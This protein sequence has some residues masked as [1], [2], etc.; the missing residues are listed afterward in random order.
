MQT[1]RD[2]IQAYQFSAG[3]L[4]HAVTSGDTGTGEQPLRRGNLGV[5]LGTVIAMLLSGGAVVYGLISP[6]ADNSWK[7]QG[8]IIVE[9]ET[10]TRYVLL[11]G[12]LRPTANYASARL[13]GS[14]KPTIY[15][16]KH[17]ALAAFPIGP[18]IGIAGAPDTLPTAM[19]DGAWSLCLG[20]AGDGADTVL[21]LVPAGHTAAVPQQPVLITEAAS[22]ASTAATAA[23]A[24]TA[25]TASGGLGSAKG[26]ASGGGTAASTSTGAAAGGATKGAAS[27]PAKTTGKTADAAPG[28][29]GIGSEYVLWGAKKYPVPNPSVLAALGLG[30]E[31]PLQAS[32]TW[33]GLLPTGDPLSPAPVAS[34]HANGPRIAGQPARV[35]QLFQ[36]TAAGVEQFYVLLT[37]GLAPITRTEAALFETVHGAGKPASVDPSDIAAAPVSA[38][39]S[40]L[41]RLPDLM[42][43]TPFS[44]GQARLCVD[45]A[46]AGAGGALALVTEDA[47]YFPDGSPVLIP[48]G[49]GLIA[50]S[51]SVDA[52]TN[53][54]TVFLVDDAG[55]R[56][57]IDGGDTYQ[58]L[59]FGGAAGHV[60]PDAVLV[61]IP[62]GPSLSVAAAK[63]AVTWSAG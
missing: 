62:P 42:T 34:A 46:K 52:A 44:P 9:K 26:T 61:L 53:Q 48:A 11:D 18:Q 25:V 30:D 58:A 1:R 5:V 24:T 50:E 17:T 45:Q 21:D 63:R 32:A 54:P 12:M 39:Q 20:P 47:R 29:A 4:V 33:L 59:G 2:H 31:A 35:G 36:A 15:V 60:L 56:F 10:G 16:V 28:D 22:S 38:D 14:G 41:R 55:E 19:L 27:S 7:S 3:R 37:D 51:T 6:A 57:T 49:R 8:S 13:A 43:S 40:L 23:P